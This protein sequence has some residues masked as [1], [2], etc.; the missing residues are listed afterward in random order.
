MPVGRTLFNQYRT[1]RVF[2]RTSAG[3]GTILFGGALLATLLA[4][5]GMHGHY[6]SFLS[7]LVSIR[8]G[9]FVLE[10]SAALWIND[11]LMAVFFL[12]VG[13]E[14]KREVLTGT[15]S[16]Y[17]IAMVPVVAAIGGMAAP[18]LIFTAFNF[19]DEIYM[20][21]WAVPTATD[22]A[23]SLGVLA[24]LGS[25][26]PLAA[27]I[28]LTAIAVVDDLLAI[29]VIAIFYSAE[30]HAD[31]LVVCFVIWF[32]MMGLNRFGVHVILPYMIL[33]VFMWI[34][35]H[36][37]G[38]HATIAGVLTASAIPH[39]KVEST[40]DTPL[41]FLQHALHTPV[42][43]GILPLFAF[44]NAGLNFT[45]VNPVEMFS[46]SLPIGITVG[47]VLGKPIGICGILFIAYKLGIATMPK[48]IDKWLIFGISCL[49]GIGFTV[50]LFIGNLAFVD[51]I[52]NTQELV[53][54]VKVGVFVG[55]LIAGGIG[56]SV[57]HWVT[58]KPIARA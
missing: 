27:K 51:G 24:L 25:R 40:V 23:F 48:E 8:I 53:N 49:C 29:L 55:S 12:L 46:D 28:F 47:L 58:S 39:G 7:T 32:M 35:M 56:Y 22:I 15:L 2:L 6:Q 33:G 54:Q 11:A 50:S 36:A 5:T 17:K 52:E 20:R 9:E 30:I 37:S 26:V 16:N 3:A 4:N 43:Y 34:Y 45:G 31:Y 18:A 13:L 41:I 44:A 57:L 38:V 1:V 21:A 42:T 19:G 10:D 14:I